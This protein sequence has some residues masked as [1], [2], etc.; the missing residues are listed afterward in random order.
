MNDWCLIYDGYEP[1]QERL[2]ETLCALGNG[3]FVTRG[4][5]TDCS[6]GPNHYP[7]TYF[8]GVY[9]RLRTDMQ[10]QLIENEDLVNWPNWLPLSICVEDEAWFSIDAVDLLSYR[11]ELRLDEGILYRD[12]RFRDAAGRVT[13]WEERRFVGMHD[14]H[15]AGL[16]VNISAENW[17]GQ[18]T[19]RSAL[20]GT[21]RN[22][23]VQRYR[24]LNSQHTY[25]VAVG[26]LDDETIM[27]MART[28]QSRIEVAQVARTRVFRDDA[29]VDAPC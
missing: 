4:A 26:P 16:A 17:S 10:G 13:R 25:V 14:P 22:E 29:H 9:N 7:G 3:Y 8:A 11:Q 24:D 6:A 20:D 18:M 23:G 12:F 28:K 27:L 1:E 21:V 5:G 2:R 15:L 19:V